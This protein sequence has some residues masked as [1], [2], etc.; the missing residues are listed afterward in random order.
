MFTDEST[1]AVLLVDASNAFNS[2][3]HQVALHNISMLC[4]SLATILINTYRANVPLFIDGKHLRKP[5]R[6]IHWQ[7]LCMIDTIRHCDIQQAWFADDAT[8]A[9]S[10]KGLYK[11]RSSLVTLGSA[12]GYNVKPSKSWLIVKTEHLD[13]EKKVFAGCGVGITAEGKHHLGAAIG[14]P[15]F[16]KHYVSEKVDYWVSCALK[17]SVIAK[18]QS[19]VAYCAFTHG[20]VGKWTYFL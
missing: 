6:G 7:W 1:E 18:I 8:A 4:P 11:W 9:G 15:I 13:L 17:L 12:Y 16:V 20:L 14:S 2:L 19:D 5:H 10:L 3:N